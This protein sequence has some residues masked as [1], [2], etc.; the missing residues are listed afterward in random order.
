MADKASLRCAIYTRTSSEERLAMDYNSLAAQYD[1]CAAFI[2]S[3]K[4]EGWVRAKKSY[5]D[6]GFSGGSLERPALQALLEDLAAGEIDIIVIYKIDRLTRSLRD[7]AKLS[8]TLDR[9]GVFF[10]AVT[11]QFN[12]ASSMGRLTLNMLLTFAQFEREV[13]GDRIR[14]KKASSSRKG[15]WMGGNPA[16][17]YDAVAKKLVV[18]PDEAKVVQYI[19]QRFLSLKSMGELRRDLERNGIVSKKKITKNGEEYG[20]KHFTWH[21]LHKILTNPLYRGLI[22]NNSSTYT[23]RH[24]AIVDVAVFDDVQKLVE[25]VAAREKR[26]RETAY[27]AL[28]RSIIFDSAGERLYPKHSLR[29]TKRHNYYVTR[30]LMARRHLRDANCRM[31]VSAPK[32]ERCVLDLLSARLRNK[33]WLLCHLPTMRQFSASAARAQ[34]LANEL[35]GQLTCN[36]GIIPKLVTRIDL[37]RIRLRILLNRSWLLER[38]APAPPKGKAPYGGDPI[39]ISMEGHGIRCGVEMR[40]VL[41]VTGAPPE[42]DHRLVRG[43]LRATRWFNA[44]VSGEFATVN[45]LA[46]A[47]GCCPTLISDRIR[48]AFL[49]PDIV[50]AILAGRQ[51]KSLTLAKLERARPFPSSWA[52]QRETFMIPA[53]E[54]LK[55]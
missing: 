55:R 36:T 44:L 43:V 39:V 16:L 50:E 51:P 52:E 21:P 41:D 29:G 40:A 32:L 4:H 5:E 6:G 45:D 24:E 48:L 8:E 42:P 19:F 2:S 35:E 27:P 30:S 17:G 47:E 33:N 54:L 12:T 3:Q 28:L 11:Q 53:Q 26:R 1:A 15:L 23:G 31:R 10:V 49:A 22:R 9:F 14:D 20:G 46:E 18:N 37:D 34:I 38:L 25:Q 13:A 7:F